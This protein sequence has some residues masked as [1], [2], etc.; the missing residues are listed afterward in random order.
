[1]ITAATRAFVRRRAQ[2]RCE[3]C[4]AHQ[5]DYDFYVFHIEHII[6][7]QHGGSDNVE[8]LCLSCPPCNA[9]KGTNLTGMLAER[10]SLSSARIGTAQL[11]TNK[12]ATLSD[13]RLKARS[14]RLLD[15][16]FRRLFSIRA[17]CGA[18]HEATCATSGGGPSKS[19]CAPCPRLRGS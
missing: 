8:N 9:A 6:P 12:M 16:L 14:S 3:Y 10:I 4:L 17:V 7:R 19:A 11:A 13:S 1:M 2:K 18:T 5:D 15:K